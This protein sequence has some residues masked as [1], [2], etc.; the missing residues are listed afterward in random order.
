MREEGDLEEERRLFYVAITRAEK[1]CFITY[2]RSRFRNGKMFYPSPSRFLRD[3]DSSLLDFEE[4]PDFGNSS[5]SS[6]NYSSSNNNEFDFYKFRGKK[7]PQIN[8]FNANNRPSY[9]SRSATSVSTIPTQ[10]YGTLKRIKTTTQ[11]PDAPNLSGFEVGEKVF[12]ERF[13]KGTISNIENLGND[14]KLT[15]QF[16]KMGERN[17]LKKYANLKKI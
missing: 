9:D 2:A 12:H 1:N 4:L 16:E 11:E 15:I 7:S 3:I 6:F 14:Y 5:K 8:G 10:S 17:I 13:G